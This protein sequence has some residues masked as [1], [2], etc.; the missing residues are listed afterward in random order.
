MIRPPP[1]ST[2]TDTLFPYTTLFRSRL[3]QIV[4]DDL[5]PRRETGLDPWLRL[6]AAL[7]RFL[8]DKTGGDHDAGVRGVGAARDRG[9]HHVAVADVVILARDRDARRLVLAI[10]F[11]EVGVEQDRTSVV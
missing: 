3:G 5:R 1:R 11:L 10:D 9:D 8:G 2:R 6:H 7:V 4:G